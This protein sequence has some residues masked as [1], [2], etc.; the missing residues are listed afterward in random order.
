VYL[1]IRQV[2]VQD[3]WS[4]VP[5]IPEASISERSGR[6]QDTTRPRF[7]AHGTGS[8]EPLQRDASR[9]SDKV[10]KNLGPDIEWVHSYVAG[11]KIYCIYNAP[12]EEMIR[13]HAKLAGLPA[14]RITPVSAVIDPT[15][16]R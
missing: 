8:T 10:L 14:N 15:T 5:P 4:S 16:A 13:A 6:P 12:S 7:Y 11:D 2:R 1:V 9:N 3:R